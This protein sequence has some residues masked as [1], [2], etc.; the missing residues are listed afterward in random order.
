MTNIQYDI[1]VFDPLI[2]YITKH[3]KMRKKS[4]CVL[5]RGGNHATGLGAI[6]CT[7]WHGLPIGRAMVPYGQGKLL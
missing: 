2:G 3:S 5:P 4:W 7:N 6:A 1:I